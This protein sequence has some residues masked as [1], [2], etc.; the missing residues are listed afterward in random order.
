MPALR[1]RREPEHVKQDLYR[2]LRY[3]SMWILYGFILLVAVSSIAA[4]VQGMQ[5]H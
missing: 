1:R 4:A 3:T 2:V 5:Q